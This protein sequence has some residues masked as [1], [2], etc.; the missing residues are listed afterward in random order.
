MEALRVVLAASFFGLAALA[1]FLFGNYDTGLAVTGAK[2]SPM[3]DGFALTA[4]IEN[5]S[6]AD[7]LLGIG[8]EAGQASIMGP[9][10][11]LAIPAHSTP[12]LAQDGVHGMLTGL[13]GESG[14]GRLVPVT[15]W[16]ERA[17]KVTTRARIMETIAHQGMAMPHSAA[18]EI[19]E[20]EPKPQVSL[21]VV[22]D[23][24]GWLATVSTEN[25]E[26]SQE[27]ADGPHTPGVGHGHVYLNGLKLQRLFEP[28]FQIGALPAG[29]HEVRVTLNTNDHRAYFV[30]GSQVTATARITAD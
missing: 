16:F 9:D 1:L 23:G 29:S 14:E 2:L 27:A 24:D 10:S 8:S 28:E 18:F 5:G 20:S 25:F 3:G 26:F 19:P 12:S 22:K 6:G 17:G 4:D 13:I 21:V 7:R 15:L 11:G 30:G